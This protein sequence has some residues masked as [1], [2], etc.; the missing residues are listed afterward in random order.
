MSEII[1][2]EAVTLSKI[3]YGDT[4][5]ILK[6]FTKDYG[7]MSVIL[8]GARSPKSKLGASA[9]TLNYVDVVFY[10]K[11]NREM[12]LVSQ[13]EILN[14]FTALRE[15]YEKMKYASA[16]TEAVERFTAD[17]EVYPLI[18]KGFVRILKLINEEKTPPELLFIKFLFF[19]I[20]E[21]GFEFHLT[22]C[23]VCGKNIGVTESAA[24]TVSQG[25]VCESCAK[26]LSSVYQLNAE[27]LKIFNGISN[28]SEQIECSLSAL[29][30]M[31]QL[32][33]RYLI[34][35]TPEFGG[36]KTFKLFG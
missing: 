34:F 5:L 3:N 29:R 26:N 31:I 7:K 18:F 15:D 6:L 22:N 24:F 32:L 33:E 11:E 14:H 25:L 12:Q 8:K 36:F 1:K 27:L 30:K 4:S 19:L 9:D 16:V 13:I 17:H 28:R 21:I 10:F 35:Q 20:K 2:T 23:S